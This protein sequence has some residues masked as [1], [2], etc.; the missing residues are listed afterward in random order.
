[1]PGLRA[2][3]VTSALGEFD[4]Q[5]DEVQGGGALD[6]DG[7]E[8]LDRCLVARGRGDFGA[9]AVVGEVDLLDRVRVGQQ[10]PRRPQAIGQVVAMRLELGR[11]AA[12][13]DRHAGLAE[14]LNARERS[15]PASA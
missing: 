4:A 11:E 2:V 12:V 3:P 15:L 13:E 10:E 14:L 9:G 1:V 8:P 7:A 5:P 6:A